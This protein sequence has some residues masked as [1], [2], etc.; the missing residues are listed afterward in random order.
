MDY[1]NDIVSFE[2]MSSIKI[3]LE[4]YIQWDMRN[5]VLFSIKQF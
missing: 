4:A 5:Q 3:C 2:N 1:N